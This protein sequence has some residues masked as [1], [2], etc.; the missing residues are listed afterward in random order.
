LKPDCF[1]LLHEPETRKWARLDSFKYN[2]R[3]D[4]P[5]FATLPRRLFLPFHAR[6]FLDTAPLMPFEHIIN[7]R[8]NLPRNTF[9]PQH[10]LG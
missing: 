3:D 5:T 9:L 10:T 2:S 1:W 6:Q 8:P 4:Y 7:H